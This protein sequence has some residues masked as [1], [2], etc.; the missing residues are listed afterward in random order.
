M[1]VSQWYA[2]VFSSLLASAAVVYLFIFAASRV[3]TATWV[4]K[5]AC[6]N[7]PAVLQGSDMAA[8][9]DYAVLFVFLLA[10]VLVLAIGNRD[11][12]DFVRRSASLSLANLVPLFLG[13]QMNSV[14]NVLG[15]RLRAYS[16]MH[17]WL[18][19]VAVV[20][21][22]VHMIAAVV[23]HKPDVRQRADV[24]G[25]IAAIALFTIAASG[26]LRQRLHELFLILH[27]VLYVAATASVFV[28]SRVTTAS[29]YP[30]ICLLV[31]ISLLS[32][33]SAL[34]VGLV[35]YRSVPYKQRPP[36][37]ASVRTVAFKTRNGADI[38]L[39]DVV[40]VH[41]ELARPWRL[42]AGQYANL[43]I[44]G[45][46]P[47]S[48]AQLH[49]FY[50]AWW[51]RKEDK[52]YAMF[53]VQTKR[54][55]TRSLAAHRDD[56]EPMLAA[57]EGPYGKQLHLDDYGTVLLM[58]T[59]IGI[60]AQLPYVSQLLEGYHNCEVRTKKIALYWQVDRDGHILDIHVYVL[61]ASVICLLDSAD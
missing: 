23:L 15:L 54:G 13:S 1:D 50:V 40:H 24:A 35:L 8:W 14:A 55:F 42:Q 44:P 59:G 48:F 46:S 61:D 17:R 25:I 18:G 58:A 41:V 38:V 39:S 7:V 34:R 4:R 47:T 33:T 36:N 30:A 21:G 3:T 31:A 26:V 6:R 49:P 2:I 53:I 37:R 29:A 43:W 12:A 45:V 28:H 56:T 32:A 57:V 9:L 19:R 16:R 20:E 11:A 51:Y 10:N 52:D 60:A 22:L 27:F 5:L